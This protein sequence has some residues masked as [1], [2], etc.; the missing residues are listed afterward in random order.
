MWSAD[1]TEPLDTPEEIDVFR[2][3]GLGWIKPENRI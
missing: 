3:L 1:S 2:N